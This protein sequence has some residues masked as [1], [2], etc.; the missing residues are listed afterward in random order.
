VDD[1]IFDPEM[2]SEAVNKDTVTAAEKPEDGVYCY[3]MFLEGCRWNYAT[4]QLAESE[5]KVLFTPAPT[6]WLRPIRSKDL[7]VFPS[8][9]CPWYRTADR[10]G[11]LATTGHSSN[12][13]AQV[14]FPI[15]PEQDAQH[16]VRRG[17]CLLM[18]LD[19]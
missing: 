8:F 17:V 11:V 7:R 4:C 3:G 2:L 14:A 10:R 18:S 5:P 6:I 1:V 19:N 12:Y 16:W 9:S 13:I 15:A